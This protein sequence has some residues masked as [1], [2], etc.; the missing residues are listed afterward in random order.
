MGAS[1]NAM[2]DLTVRMDRASIRSMIEDNWRLVL[3]H[4]NT[5][6]ARRIV[7][8]FEVQMKTL[9]STLPAEQ[10]LEFKRIVIEEGDMLAEEYHRDPESVYQRLGIGPRGPRQ[11]APTVAVQQPSLGRV[12][13]ETAIR[14]SIWEGLAALLFGGW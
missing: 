14:A 12:A 6:E 4:A 2:T 5:P 10:A 7:D 13:A 8:R 11:A 3:S 9:A 1:Q